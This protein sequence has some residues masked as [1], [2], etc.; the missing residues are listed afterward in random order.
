L[1]LDP[2]SIHSVVEAG[3]ALAGQAPLREVKV[4]GIW[5]DPAKVRTRCP[6][7]ALPP[8]TGSW[9]LA[10]NGLEH[11]HT[12]EI[13]PIVFDHSLT[14][15]RDDVVLAHLNHRLVAMCLQLLRAEVWAVTGSRKLHRITARIIPNNM[16]EV[17]VAVAHGR[18]VVLG[19]DNKRLHEELIFAGGEL[20]E[21]RFTRIQQLVA[22]PLHSPG[23]VIG[24]VS[25]L[26][27]VKMR[28]AGTPLL[29]KYAFTDS[30]RL[31]ESF[32]LY[33]S[34]PKRS[35]WPI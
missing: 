8:L 7:F 17:P 21:G 11:P 26:P 34:E 25:P 32:R 18:L 27:S 35:A 30:A 1:H 19:G 14:V 31:M 6:V 29:T 28:L 13:R 4:E 2:D 20:R 5:P 33:A 10:A 15:G 22:G 12:H 16:A 24:C 3:L 9:Q 23:L